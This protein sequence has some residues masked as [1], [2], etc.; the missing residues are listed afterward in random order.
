MFYGYRY[1]CGKNVKMCM[2]IMTNKF[3]IE[4]DYI[5]E[6]FQRGLSIVSLVSC[7]FKLGGGDVNVQ[8]IILYAFVYPN[9]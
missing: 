9:N 3:M 1:I 8:C 2:G 7:F 4:G 5:G 6:R